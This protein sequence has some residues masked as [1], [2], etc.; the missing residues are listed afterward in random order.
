VRIRY[1]VDSHQHNDYLTGI[2]ELP[3]RGDVELLAG[4]RAELGYP[5]RRLADRERLDVG[6]V[7]FEAV[8]TPGHT[9]E[10]V[11]LLVTDRSRGEEPS[12]LLSGGALLVG[13]VAR[14]DLL[15][16]REETERNAAALC[17][18][19][20]EKILTL[21]DH[22][23][24]WPTHVKGSLCGGSI[25]SRLSTTIGYERRMNAMLARL[26]EAREFV[27]RCLDLRGLP[28]VPPY[29]SRMRKQNRAG[30]PLLG[31]VGEPPALAVDAFERRRGEG[32]IVL[33]CRSPE[34]FAGGHVPGA[35]NVGAGPS[36]L[37]WAGSVLPADAAVVLVLDSARDLEDV[38]WDLLRIG[39]PAPDGWL[40]GGMLAWRTAAKPIGTVETW[41][42]W[43]LH[44]RLRKEK[45]LLVLDVRQPKEW[46]AGHV[47]GAVHVTGAEL[48]RRLGELPRERPI[49][50]I[51]GSG[52]RSGVAASVLLANG[53][54]PVRNV[55]GGMTAWKRAGLPATPAEEG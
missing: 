15:G 54:G 37:T 13:D 23:E 27:G 50:T 46:S 6:E 18:T 45:D 21:P 12:L 48:V 41:T 31:V 8:H 40:A 44:E 20:R 24:V 28:A 51:C 11:S 52:Y 10:H 43:Q 42:V 3:A 29:W 30:P 49:A 4:A 26:D 1:A 34:A 7:R 14:P 19:L 2:C 36:F 16:G 33:D 32:A 53:F 25:G 55:L 39:Y 17:R 35:L 22:V 47:E 38:V 9:T 5:V